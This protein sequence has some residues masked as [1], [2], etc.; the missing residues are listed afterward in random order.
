LFFDEKSRECWGRT[1]AGADRLVVCIGPEGGWDH[2]EVEAADQAG[3]QIL[4]LG[5]RILR[6][7]TAAVAALAILQFQYGDL[8]PHERG[9]T[10]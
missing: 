5:P 3:Y 6:T 9:E 2:A 1:F 8:G 10:A 4:N 7:E